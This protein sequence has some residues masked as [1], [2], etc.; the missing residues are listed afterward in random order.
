MRGVLLTPIATVTSLCVA[1]LLYHD[2]AT[3]SARATGRGTILVS[4]RTGSRTM[5]I[6]PRPMTL[7]EFLKKHEE[8]VVLEYAHGVVTE[9]MPPA[10]DHGLLAGLIG[11][12]INAFALPRKLGVAGVEIRST[13]LEAGVSRVPDLSVFVWDRIE[14]DRVARGLSASIPP[15]IAIEIASPGQG[16]QQQIERCR[17]FIDQGSRIAMMFDPRTKSVIDVRPGGIERRLRGDDVL[18]L[19]DVIPGLTLIVG[20]LFALL[21][22]E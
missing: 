6:A 11:H 1:L 2:A 4:E 18:D 22:F 10:Y 9:K 13:D 16:R 8:S 14:R 15:D 3:S 7:D 19:S 20:D 21:R 17:E 5:A 12:Q